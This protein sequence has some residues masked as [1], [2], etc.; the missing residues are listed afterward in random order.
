MRRSMLLGIA[1]GA[2]IALGS[3]GGA[4]AGERAG[5]GHETPAGE[6]ARSACAFSGLED[7]DFGAPVQPGTV[8]NWGH[9]P[10][11]A[12]DMFSVRGAAVVSTP[13]GEEGCNANL[14]P[15]K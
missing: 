5:D 7:F 9:I 8:Q 15:N 6:K 11:E 10:K 1:V 2:V 13:F 3:G 14:Y 12:R 4:F